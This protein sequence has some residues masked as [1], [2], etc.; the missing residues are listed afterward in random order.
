MALDWKAVLQDPL[1]RDFVDRAGFEALL[2]AKGVG[3]NILDVRS[4]QEFA[5]EILAP[6]HFP[7]EQ[8]PVPGHVRPR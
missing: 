3:K 5:G 8:P 4:P 6:A 1:R 2:S 7:Q